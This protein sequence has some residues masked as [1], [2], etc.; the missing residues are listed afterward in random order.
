MYVSYRKDINPGRKSIFCYFLVD[1]KSFEYF[2]VD[3]TQP[4]G[5]H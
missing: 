3:K 2:E 5:N 4:P 1:L